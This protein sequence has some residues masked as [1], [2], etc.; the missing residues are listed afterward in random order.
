MSVDHD[1]ADINVDVGR[2]SFRRFVLRSAIPA[3]MAMAQ[4]TASMALG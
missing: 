1:I 2:R 3:C 4:V